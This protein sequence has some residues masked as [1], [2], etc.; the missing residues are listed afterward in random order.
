MWESER[1]GKSETFEEDSVIEKGNE[2][3]QEKVS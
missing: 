2:M 1:L 3:K